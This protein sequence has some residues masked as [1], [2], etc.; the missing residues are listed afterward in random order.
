M[1]NEAF[2]IMLHVEN[3]LLLQQGLLLQNCLDV[4][5]VDE[6]G[7][8]EHESHLGQLLFDDL[9]VELV[10]NHHALGSQLVHIETIDLHR[11]V[12]IEALTLI[13]KAKSI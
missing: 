4:E 13:E 1:R 3:K 12:N 9:L 8:A 2:K 11:F 7:H 6:V 10:L 5:Y